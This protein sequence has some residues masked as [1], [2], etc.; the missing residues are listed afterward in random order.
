M[1]YIEEMNCSI[2]KVNMGKMSYMLV[3]DCAGYIQFSLVKV[4]QSI[5]LNGEFDL[6]N[7]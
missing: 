3:G 1:L 7:L 4:P 6:P 5:F 2:R